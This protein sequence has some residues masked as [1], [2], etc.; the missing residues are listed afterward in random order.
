[1]RVKQTAACLAVLAIGA[2]F[3]VNAAAQ[4]VARS[5]GELQLRVKTGDTV[6]VIDRSRRETGGRIYLLS[7]ASLQL[8]FNG[9]RREF[10]ETDVTRIERRGR[11]SEWSAHR[12]GK[13]CGGWISSRSGC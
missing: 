12:A 2:A 8:A 13:R 5:F 11:D 4:T 10:L 7:P 1:M 9:N 3:S 6:Y